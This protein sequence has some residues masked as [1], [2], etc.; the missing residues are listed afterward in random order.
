MQSWNLGA[1]VLLGVQG[2]ELW[3]Q[4][5]KR[6]DVSGGAGPHANHDPEFRQRR[7]ELPPSSS[8]EHCAVAM[9]GA[10]K[11]GGAS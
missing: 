7:R 8:H 11:D 3:A 5:E 10:T 2:Y 9:L 1:G 6:Q 4:G